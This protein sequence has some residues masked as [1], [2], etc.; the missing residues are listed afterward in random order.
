VP[1][2]DLDDLPPPPPGKTGW[3][4]TAASAPWPER[5]P[6]GKAWP[7]VGVVTPT[8]N[9]ARFIEETVRSVLLQGHPDIEY[10]IYDGGSKDGTL[11]ILRRY[12]PWL[13]YWTSEPD[14]G[15][16][17]AAN[18]GFMRCTSPILGWLNSDDVF[19]PDAVRRALEMFEQ[20]PGAGLLYGRISDR[21]EHGEPIQRFKGRPF[22]LEEMIWRRNP[23]A[24]SSAF[25]LKSALERVGWLD[26]SLHYAM[27]FDLWLRLGTEVQ[28]VFV[29]EIW[30]DFRYYPSS[31]SGEGMLPFL[32]EIDRSL[33]RA[34]A[35]G[36]LP[37]HLARHRRA[38]LAQAKL[39]VG[40]EFYELDRDG[41]ARM[42]AT[43]ALLRDPRLLWTSWRQ[44][45]RCLLGTRGVARLKSIYR[46]TRG[47]GRL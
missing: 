32:I 24:Q 8:L 14:R 37:P 46:L 16:S 7:R 2:I 22:N 9:Q 35:S 42:Q 20:N 28:A 33:E 6:Q 38:A 41:E 25:V 21:D 10:V 1:R 11:D 36:K 30:S 40:M 26:E 39:V 34:F 45:V 17:H 4:W 19:R 44:W 23:V 27:D 31:K 5:T 3:P 43:R 29:D 13:S 18:K 47:R 12:E 15:Q